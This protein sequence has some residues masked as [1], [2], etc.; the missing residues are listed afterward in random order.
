MRTWSYEEAKPFLRFTGRVMEDPERGGIWINWT[1]AGFLVRFR[2]SRLELK[3]Q[4]IGSGDIMDPSAPIT[5][6]PFVGA[7]EDD[8]LVNR[9][10]CRGEEEWIPFYE[11]DAG[12]HTLRFVKLTEASRAQL[13][14]IALRT[15]GE[16]M[17]LPPELPMKRV[18]FIG[19]SITCGYGNEEPDKDEHFKARTENGWDSYA[20]RAAREIGADWSVIAVSG[21]S[22]AGPKKPKFDFMKDVAMERLYAWTD[23]AASD[24]TGVPD[25]VWDFAEKPNDIVVLNLGTN[26]ATGISFSDNMPEEEAYFEERYRAFIETIR[27]LNGP[28]TYIVCALGTLDYYLYDNIKE[29]VKKYREDTGDRRISTYKFGHTAMMLEGFGADM[30]PSMKTHIRMGKELAAFLQTIPD[31]E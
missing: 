12:T 19:D 2:G 25:V 5:E 27:K 18:E 10:E 20:V 22:V 24:K 8:E 23:R 17:E 1:A 14:L 29:I 28:E 3:V 26:D 15:E 4:A 6:F 21:I 7:V 30:H 11:G 31:A 16:L 9:V 13:R